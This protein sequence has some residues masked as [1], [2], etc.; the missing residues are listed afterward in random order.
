MIMWGCDPH[1]DGGPVISCTIRVRRLMI[2]SYLAKDRPSNCGGMCKRMREARMV[3]FMTC[4]WGHGDATWQP[5]NARPT[6]RSG[7]GGVDRT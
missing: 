5:H 6:L 1:V 4:S 3:L 7:Y 2:G